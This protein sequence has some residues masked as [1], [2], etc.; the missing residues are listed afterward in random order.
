MYYGIR[1]SS[2]C[3]YCNYINEMVANKEEKKKKVIKPRKEKD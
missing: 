1:E 2:F 3:E